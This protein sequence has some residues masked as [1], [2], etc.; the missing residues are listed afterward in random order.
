MDTVLIKNINLIKEDAS[1]INNM[2]VR[3]E[4]GLIAAIGPASKENASADKTIDG[5]GLYLS[6]GI[7]NLHAHTAM[8]IFKGI[9]ED[10]T[11][12]QWFNEKI[13]PF[14]S[15]M[16]PEDV[17]IGTRLGIAEM[18]NN[19]VTVC[20]DHYF[21]EEEVLK[22]FKDAGIR[23]DI[24]PTVFG[25]APD[26]KKRLSDT[27][28]FIETHKNDSDRISFSAGPHATY[29]CPPDTL[30]EIVDTAKAH[31]LRIHIHISEEK[32]QL[33]LCREAYGKTPFEYLHD[34]GAFEGKV[35]LAHG[36]WMVPEDLKFVNDDTFI[37][38][39]PKTYM[40]LGSGR[41]GMFDIYPK[42]N[43]AFGTDGAASSNTLNP[44]EQARLFAL[45]NKF[46]EFDGRILDAATVWKMLMSGH[47]AFSFNSGKIE[48]GAAADLVIWDL[49]TADTLPI[50]DPVTAI[51]Y[52]SN[53][54]NVRYTMTAG[55]FLKYDGKLSDRV[56]IDPETIESV[57]KEL[58]RRGK[59]E[60]KVSYLRD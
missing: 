9:A 25:T 40:K 47:R 20:A 37:A 28:E 36:L 21:M 44:V 22:A 59:G 55:E 58:V 52:S 50:Y 53:S 56:S 32:A 24:A 10:C 15:K 17:Y 18:V 45:I 49:S 35:L 38:F 5:T 8:N 11:S 4:K 39:C 48:K 16:T 29:T 30:K 42:L 27:T 31:S 7:P 19:G 1:V 12:D 23:A 60:A 6:P 34:S 54:G 2:D 13:F 46:T 41:G 14:E 51:L 33:D 3:I 57:R 26:F 43:L